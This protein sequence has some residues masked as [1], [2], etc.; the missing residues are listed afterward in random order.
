MKYEKYSR[1][2]SISWGIFIIVAIL[3]GIGLILTTTSLG[4]TF[5][6]LI[7]LSIPKLIEIILIDILGNMK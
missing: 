5:G 6:F 7:F 1:F 4:W 3:K 2:I